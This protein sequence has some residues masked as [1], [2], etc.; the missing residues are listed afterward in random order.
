[1][2]T[3]GMITLIRNVHKSLKAT[4]GFVVAWSEGMMEAWE[5]GLKNVSF[6]LGLTKYSKI[7]S[8]VMDTQPTLIH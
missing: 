2:T 8:M 7:D 1:M 6:L 4:S 5:L 3:Y